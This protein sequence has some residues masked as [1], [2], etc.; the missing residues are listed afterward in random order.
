MCYW[1][2]EFL[3]LADMTLFRFH[4]AVD[5]FIVYIATDWLW[6]LV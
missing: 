3:P 4:V 6:K 1:P 2:Y 5:R